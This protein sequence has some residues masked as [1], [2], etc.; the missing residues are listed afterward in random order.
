AVPA[1]LG[2]SPRLADAMRYGSLGGGNRI[3]PVLAYTACALCGGTD[4]Q[5]AAPAVAVQLIHAYSL[6]QHD[7]PAMDDDDL[8][9]GRA[10]CHIAYDEAT[11]ILAGDTLQTRAFAVLSGG[12][13]HSDTA[14]LA[15]V[16][17]L[18]LA[19]GAAGMA[20]GQMQ[21]MQPHGQMLTL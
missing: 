7:L 9:R 10:T 1:D 8:R 19:A 5:A 21:D 13:A 3:R 16:R 4:D 6:V 17:T 15:M 11:A 2:A 14:R 12:G 18:A 20:A